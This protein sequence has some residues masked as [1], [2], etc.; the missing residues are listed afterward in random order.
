DLPSSPSTSRPLTFIFLDVAPS[1]RVNRTSVFWK[2]K[3]EMLMRVAVLN[4]AAVTVTSYEPTAKSGNKNVPPLVE[5]VSFRTPV[6]ASFKVTLALAT[7][8]P[9]GSR[10]VP[11]TAPT[12]RNC[13]QALGASK[14][15]SANSPVTFKYTLGF[16]ACGFITNPPSEKGPQGEPPRLNNWM[17]NG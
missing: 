14:I 7:T 2:V 8:A 13:A 6:C 11:E 4:P 9:V 12:I 5:V 15:V 3:R 10:M 16:F 17:D 1:P